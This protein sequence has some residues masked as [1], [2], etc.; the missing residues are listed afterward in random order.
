[1]DLEW[2]RRVREAAF[3][4][5]RA[6][7][8]RT[9]GPVTRRD[10]EGFTVD[11]ERIV[12]MDRV[13]GITTPRQLEAALAI[14][15]V[16]PRPGRPSP[17]ADEPGPDGLLRYAWQGTD[18]DLLAN[19][20]LRAALHHGLELLWFW[21]LSEGVYL[22]VFP[23]RLVGEEPHHRRFVV[24]LDPEQAVLYA[25]GVP[26]D[27][28]ARRLAER[29]TR[30]RLHQPRFRIQVLRAYG[31]RCAL[32]R[33]SRPPLLDA[34]HIRPDAEGG[35]PVVPNGIAMCKIHHAAWDAYL[36]GIDPDRRI[37]LRSD[38]LAEVD[39]PT[40]RHALQELHGRPLAV[41]PRDE[42][43]RPDPEALEERWERFLRAT[44]P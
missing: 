13:R 33:L 34:A 1:M 6:V 4:F 27:E 43:L 23:V 15:T 17:Y 35:R 24:A 14:T 18:G 2:E 31:E 39:G 26:L 5:L 37:H 3:A 28:A 16:A 38:L 42:R 10:L 22:P 32:C 12:L 44:A 29:I 11:G 7:Q 40:L 21:G 25:T 30:Q 19:R 36:L 20:K 9:G 8:L 41:V